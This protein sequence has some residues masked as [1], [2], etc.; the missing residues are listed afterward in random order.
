[1]GVHQ[2]CEFIVLFP[3]L[4]IGFGSNPGIY[5]NHYLCFL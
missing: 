5:C 4:P 1:M 3:V 2:R